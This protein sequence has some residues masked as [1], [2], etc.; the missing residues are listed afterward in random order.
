MDIKN[1]GLIDGFCEPLKAI[2][3]H[4]K[5]RVKVTPVPSEIPQVNQDEHLFD[6]SPGKVGDPS[7]ENYQVFTKKSLIW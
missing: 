1:S 5:E 4:I 2:R 6:E 7:S 3:V